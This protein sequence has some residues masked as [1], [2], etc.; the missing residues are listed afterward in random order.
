MTISRAY[1]DS[2]AMPLRLVACVVC[3]LLSLSALAGERPASAAE[4]GVAQPRGVVVPGFWD[5]R[6]RPER[7]DLS[8]IQTIRF[9]TETDYPP[10]DY[11]G[12]D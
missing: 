2:P 4:D 1:P 5:S 6:R 3:A 10:F 12:P 7:P 11:A 9:L 8:R